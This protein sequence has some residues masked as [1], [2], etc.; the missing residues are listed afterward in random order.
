MQCKSDTKAV[1]LFHLNVGFPKEKGLNRQ[2]YIQ[3]YIIFQFFYDTVKNSL[4]NLKKSILYQ[5]MSIW[6]KSP[7]STLL[8]TIFFK[9]LIVP[10]QDPATDLRIKFTASI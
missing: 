3:L 5:Y 7:L 4:R 9:K 10:T 6:R 2:N 8:K 1:F